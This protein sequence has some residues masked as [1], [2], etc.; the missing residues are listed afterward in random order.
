MSGQTRRFEALL[1]SVPDALV[2]M[3]QNG[4]IR[5]VNRQTESLFGYDR[6]QLIG[7]RIETLVPDSLWQIYAEHRDIYFADP[8]S[9]SSG[10]DLE[11]SGREQS[12]TEFPIN[13]S[14]SSIDTGDV[15][16]VITAVRD[17]TQQKQAVKTAELLAAIVH[18]S[19]DAIISGSLDGII[20]SW[21]PASERMYGYSSAEV[22]GKPAAFLTP[23]DREGEVNAVLAQIKAGKHVRQLE[24]KR[25]R[26]DGT[27]FPV[28]LTVSPIRNADGAVI[29]TSVIHRDLSVQKGALAA[30]QRI[31]AMVE[32]CDDAIIGRTLDGIIT[33][34]NPAAARMFGYS[35]QEIVGKPD[36]LLS[37]KDR[38]GERISMLAKI[39]AGRPVH[40]ETT[41]VR[42]D[43][44]V[45]PVLLTISPIRDDKAMV[46]GSSVICRDVSELRLAAD[47]NRSL[48]EAALDLLVTI[49]RN[50]K[51][52]D[53]NEATVKLAG[54]PRGKLI[55]TDF[56]SYF[57]D[58][59]KAHQGFQQ[60][61]AQGSVT[62]YPLTLRQ[63]DGTL[64][65]VL[66]N[67]SVYC[68][69]GGNV[70]GVLADARDMTNRT[71]AHEETARP[72]SEERQ[73]IERLAVGP[74]LEM[75]EQL[76]RQIESLRK[77]VMS[78]RD[79]PGG[80]S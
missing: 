35:S 72:H 52:T 16:L 37:P 8:R 36:E 20:T 39:S 48:I 30:A 80:R 68:D 34:W 76:Q 1:E 74:E 15:L 53:V 50:G 33:S 70:C 71:Q 55:G 29:G 6:D 2:G 28:S 77:L 64:T 21:N 58:P 47:Y 63:R 69:A 32:F 73:R 23:K 42:K 26:K 60:A 40:L 24:T 78:K 75:I 11:L 79:E 51:I 54:V 62:D 49:S 3:D 56:S 4:V 27:V 43:G 25:V 9:R 45:F 12:G 22:I 7:Q 46:V 31:A 67:A 44:T 19:E 5:F 59:D 17:V 65:E 14:L 18:N 13:I 61:F 66:C 41:R 57:T 38:A 10:L